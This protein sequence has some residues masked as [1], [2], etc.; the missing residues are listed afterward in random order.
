MSTVAIFKNLSNIS[1]WRNKYMR[2]RGVFDIRDAN[3]HHGDIRPFACPELVCE[4]V[5]ELNYLHPL[6]QC[7]CFGFNNN[8]KLV[9][10]FCPNQY[11][12]LRGGYLRWANETEVCNGT[13]VCRAGAPFKKTAPSVSG[14]CGGSCS[15]T[16]VSYVI[17]YVTSSTDGPDVEGPPSPASDP[18]SVSGTSPNVTVSWG[19][20]PSAYCIKKTRL[21]RTEGDFG[22][23]AGNKSSGDTEW[24]LVHEWNGP[25]AAE[26]KTYTDNNSIAATGYPLT[27]YAPMAFPAPGN[28]VDLTRSENGIIVADAHRLYISINGA[29]QFTWDGVVEIEDEIIRIEHVNGHI[30]IFTTCHPVVV[31][32]TVDRNGEMRIEKKVIDRNLP[33]TSW[34]SVSVY[35]NHVMFAST[36]SLY[37]WYTDRFAENINSLLKPLLTPEQWK[38]IDPY[39]VRGTQYE[40]G[41]ILFSDKLP[42][43]L[44][45]QF[46]EDG[47]DTVQE[48]HLMP[49]TYIKP[50]SF[51]LDCEGHI[52]YNENG[53][54]YRWDWR[55]DLC[56]QFEV[57]DHVR[58][59][60]CEDCECCP[61]SA[62]FFFDNEGKNHFSHMRVEWDE[63]S[64]KNL[65]ISFHIHEF[66]REIDHTDTMEII[67]S[68][69]F[70]I[71]FNNVSYQS[72][73]A[74]IWGCG[75]VHEVKIAT[76]A[77]E[78]AYGVNNAIQG[79]GEQ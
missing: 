25:R 59:T 36:Y 24:V 56:F 9:R 3:L 65:G 74:Y 52:I 68:R 66:G 72:C 35:R 60:V 32:Y 28:L 51:G 34:R 61:W 47:T 77:H 73:Y 41:Y 17:T 8:R 76:S 75:I 38:N 18:I 48:T 63:R 21:Y 20:A 62:K 31:D 53:N 6:E 4:N 54:M 57:F 43:S 22:E 2:G 7:E 69:G 46:I 70:G 64:A 10:G 50:R 19:D 37:Q 42:Y 39:T 23:S 79:E 45:L 40:Y 49:I 29:P 26:G 33:L 14:G 30:Y 1:P 15:A 58:P 71:P 12:Y 5:G 67:S 13:E 78:L 16:M 55:R 27:T 11:F 44:M